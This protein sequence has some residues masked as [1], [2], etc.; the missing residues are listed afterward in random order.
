MRLVCV[1]VSV[2]VHVCWL[3]RYTCPRGWGGPVGRAGAVGKARGGA[4]KAVV[5]E[6][7]ETQ[8]PLEQCRQCLMAG[9]S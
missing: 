1:C 7:G 8:M 5:Q 9:T 6:D 4:V 3:R 2:C